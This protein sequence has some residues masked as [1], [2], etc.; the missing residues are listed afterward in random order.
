MPVN[1]INGIKGWDENIIHSPRHSTQR[2]WRDRR[3]PNHAGSIRWR[4]RYYVAWLTLKVSGSG[5]TVPTFHY[6]NNDKG[7]WIDHINSILRRTYTLPYCWAWLRCNQWSSMILS[8]RSSCGRRRV[9]WQ[10][11][12]QCRRMITGTGVRHVRIVH[13]RFTAHSRYR[14]RSTGW[15]FWVRDTRMRWIHRWMYIIH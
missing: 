6:K 10:T 1:K 2:I 8:K 12:L 15:H 9:R 7:I 4:R 5:R 13:S 3:I 11:V 14:C